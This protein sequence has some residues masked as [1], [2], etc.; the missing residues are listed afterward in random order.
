MSK[1][2][3]CGGACNKP[4]ET[5]KKGGCCGGVGACACKAGAVDTTKQAG[6][7][8]DKPEF[9]PTQPLSEELKTEL[10]DLINTAKM[11]CF[12]KGSPSDPRCKFSKQL[13]R[14]LMDNNITRLAYHDILEDN[15]VREALKVYS[16]WKTFPQ[17]YIEGKLIGGID[18]VR[19]L[20]SKGQLLDKVP[21][22]CFGSGLYPRIRKLIDQQYVMLF[23]QGTPEEPKTDEDKQI[24]AVLKESGAEYGYFDVLSAEDV[25]RAA[26]VYARFTVYPQL[27]VAGEP[28]GGLSALQEKQSQGKLADLLKKPA[29][30]QTL[31]TTSKA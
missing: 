7:C 31:S 28:A 24:L 6:C 9:D 10:H 11:T 13:I 3:C 16:N 23:M 26:P 8:Q 22:E 14:F 19:D 2:G 1:G 20:H 30:T 15:L 4:K 21:K 27:F 18:A 17:I 25:A 29:S 12:I 5:E